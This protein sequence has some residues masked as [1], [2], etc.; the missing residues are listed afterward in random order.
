MANNMTI[1]LLAAAITDEVNTIDIEVA[2]DQFFPN[3]PFYVTVSPI[4]EPPTALNSEIMAVRARNGKTLTVVRGQRGIVAKVHK[5]GSL[6][7][8]GVYYENL[9]HVGDIVTTLNTNPMPGRLLLNGQGGYSKWDYPLLYEHIRTNPRYGTISGDT[10]SLVDLRSKFPLIAG[11]QDPVASTGGSKTIQLAPQNYQT[12]TWMS[13]TISQS[14]PVHG[15]VNVGNSLGFHVHATT[16]AANDSSKNV[17]L[18]WRPQYVALN[19]E[20]VAG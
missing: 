15:A 12:N 13:D 17:P 2:Y 7:Y 18:E 19:F 3:A 6:V 4:D 9:L 1:G 8:R 14:G 16:R 20:I 5:K 10:F 11:G